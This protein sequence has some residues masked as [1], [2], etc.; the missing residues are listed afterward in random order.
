MQHPPPNDPAA[1][2]REASTAASAME[3]AGDM[4]PRWMIRVLLT[5][6]ALGAC[7]R[8]Y[9]LYSGT[10]HHQPEL[11]LS[12]VQGTGFAPE[13]YRVGVRSAAWWMMQRFGWGFRHGFAVMDIAASLLAIFLLYDLLLRK[14]AMRCASM[15]MQW[16]ASASFVMLVCFYLAWLQFFG[17]PET[18][19]S[20]G[21]AAVL[22]WLWSPRSEETASGS[23]QTMVV[24]GLL[25]AT[26][27]L[28]TIRA[29]VACLLS[30]GMFLASVTRMGA[31]MALPKRI[32]M[33]TSGACALLAAGIQLYLM[34]M[35]YPQTTY[36]PTH[37]LMARYDLYRPLIWVSFVLFMV[38]VAWTGVQFWRQR[39][40][41][42][43]ASAGL[44][45]GSALYLILWVVLGKLDEVRIFIPFALALAPLTVELAVR[46]LARLQG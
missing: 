34:R 3:K 11:W 19:P 30:A 32:A 36:G 39:A 27:L 29:D 37:W 14:R 8:S 1:A 2:Q 10:E 16:F 38:P 18:L 7:E 12:L 17:K 25:A 23:R 44:V 9:W 31:R 43:G 40:E 15:A 42:D 33:L 4:G 24:C 45:A 21:L 22:L 28:A 13:Q 20:A 6:A 46:R 41:E 5:A 26:A 35:V